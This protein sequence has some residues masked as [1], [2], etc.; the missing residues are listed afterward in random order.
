MDTWD[1]RVLSASYT[2]DEDVTVQ[3]FGRTREGRSI[4][5]LYH[6]FKPYF[7]I[8]EPG[9]GI[10][11]RLG[12]DPEILDLREVHIP[13]NREMKR[14]TKVT[15]RSPWKVPSYR[16]MY[17][18]REFLAADI[19]FAQR[20]YYDMDLGGCVRVK[21]R[22]VEHGSYATEITV[23][24]EGFENIDAF[25]PALK[26]LSFDIENSIKDGHI[27]TLGIVVKDASG[28]MRTY[29]ME[30]E[31]KEIIEWFETL[32]RK[33]D[34]DIITGYNIDGYD[35]PIL[36][37][38]AEH[39][40]IKGL[41]LARD[42][43]EVRSAGERFWR[44]HGRIFADAWWSAKM[45]LR[46]KQETLDAVAKQ[47]LGEG[48]GEIDPSNIDEEWARSRERVIEYCIKDAEL[49]LRILERIAVLEKA[50]D[51]ATVSKLPLDDV[52][53]GRTS[54]LI[55]SIL[56]RE[57][58]R[59]GVAVPMMRHEKRTKQIEGGYVHSIEPGI[60]PWVIV[61]DF[62]SMYPN[63][64]IAKNICFTTLDKEGSIESPIGVRFLSPDV[65]GG[66][67]PKI[68]RE[69]MV[70][71]DETKAKMRAARSEEE[72]RYYDGLQNAI[73]TLMNAFYGVFASAFYRFTNPKIGE[74]ITTFAREHTTGIIAQLE[75]EG[76]KVV[77]GDTDSVF[78]QS[79][80]ETLD[81]SVEFGKALSKRYS[82]E[83]AVLEFERL[84]NPMFSHGV[85]KR[86][87][88]RVVW[89]EE[90]VVVRGY[91]TRRTDAFDYQ[92]ESLDIVFERIL[93]NDP[94]GAVDAAKSA[95]RDC[96]EGKV[97]LEKLVVSRTCREFKAYKDAGSQVTVQAAKK[98]MKLGY[99]FVP[100][101][102][103]SWIVVDG[104][105]TPQEVEP[106]VS[107]RPFTYTPDYEYYARRTAMT[108]AR[109]TDLYGW[110]VKDLMSGTQQAALFS[111]R[112]KERKGT[113]EKKE[114]GVKRATKAPT[115]EDFI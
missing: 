108:L 105:K 15:L 90:T 114:G 65:H 80:A 110:D 88:G 93:S 18:E 44:A 109:V 23:E 13:K 100:G 97:A 42:G 70:W 64:I 76:L 46:P 72:R 74:S 84:L 69:L 86:Y 1:V 60:Y 41:R 29:H 36:L 43:G 79:P 91:E 112:F 16:E 58:D 5:I 113:A 52:L 38:R 10:L 11:K 2:K 45:E 40:K 71:R 9:E 37:K 62:R 57:A 4:T 8:V 17:R 111:G 78:V 99:E 104:R 73:K 25:K 92:S 51:L 115:L 32:V 24:A 14:C 12:N 61:L 28:E 31:E 75:S 67:L 87:V 96:A 55:D 35:I 59:Q 19:P 21:G 3:L 27:L 102:K 30:G 33:E 6:G 47:V 20:F 85:K 54:T 26:I 49:S 94:Q 82:K 53:N 101:M 34:P 103:V 68:L 98:L 106:Y 39:H 107:G 63:L 22:E 48:K 81:G 89:P 66:I 50:M 83:G 7:Y 77:Y 95:V 56:I